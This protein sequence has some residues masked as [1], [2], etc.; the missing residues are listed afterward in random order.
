M[1]D[2]IIAGSQR[3]RHYQRGASGARRA[4]KIRSAPDSP[5]EN[6][7]NP[8]SALCAVI[9]LMTM[10]VRHRAARRPVAKLVELTARFL[11]TFA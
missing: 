4:G 5:T 8:E 10:N 1:D 7:M 11:E 9:A 6:S 2:S 3:V